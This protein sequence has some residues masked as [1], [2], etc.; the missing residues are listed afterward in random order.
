MVVFSLWVSWS[1]VVALFLVAISSRM[2]SLVMVRPWPGLLAVSDFEVTV[3]VV[4][5]L[6]SLVSYL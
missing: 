3:S 6:V 4:K 5:T 2:S 1:I